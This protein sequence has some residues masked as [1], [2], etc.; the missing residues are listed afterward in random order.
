MRMPTLA[1]SSLSS[2]RRV[3]VVLFSSPYLRL[4]IVV[5][6]FVYFAWRLTKRTLQTSVDIPY[7]DQWDFYTPL[8]RHSSLWQ[9][10]FWQHGPHREGIGLIADKFLLDWTHWSTL[11][12]SLLI[13]ACFAAAAALAVYLKC[14]LF[15]KLSYSDL[16]IPGMFLM[17]A[18][19]AAVTGVPNPSYSGF[20]ELLVMLYCLAWTIRNH[21]LRYAAVL[22]LNFLLIY[23]GF[24]FFMG[25]ITMCLLGI[26]CARTIR[27]HA[28]LL[29][30][31]ST[32]IIAAISFAGFFVDYQS[33]PARLGRCVEHPHFL[34]YPWFVN[35]EFALFVGIRRSV[36]LATVVGGA[37]GIAVIWIAARG[38]AK[39]WRDREWSDRDLTITICSG[40]SLLFALAAAFGRACLGMPAAAQNYRYLGLLT[41]ALLAIYFCL[42]SIHTVR[43]R[44][45]AVLLFM[46]AVLPPALR[47]HDDPKTEDGKRAWV[48]CLLQGHSA[49][50]CQQSTGYILHPDPATSHLQDKLDYLRANLLSLYRNRDEAKGQL[51][52]K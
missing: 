14:R 40:F 32:F 48:E 9:I 6:S 19:L 24:G 18:H 44:T 25:L 30:P 50:E 1:L 4:A 16:V 23:T 52:P 42:L 7:W 22:S 38:A 45:I 15:G 17:P 29:V 35:L 3:I 31:L 26:N 8:F 46:V 28:S 43:A 5:I 49:A 13:A 10:F 11:A 47:N 33:A 21:A 20:P 51:N 34:Y 37:I 2:R 36:T 12:E 39:L 27:G 41:P